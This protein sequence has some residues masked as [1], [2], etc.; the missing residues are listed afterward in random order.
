MAGAPTGPRAAGP[1]ARR[2]PGGLGPP[3][4]AVRAAGRG[5]APGAERHA[6]PLF[7]VLFALDDAGGVGRL[8][9]V[10]VERVPLR[11]VEA[12]FDLVLHLEEDGEEIRGACTFRA[13]SSTP[14]TA[15]R[16]GSTSGRCSRGWP[17]PPRPGGRR[18]PARRAR[19]GAAVLDGWGE[20]PAVPAGPLRPRAVRGAGRAHPG[21]GR[22]RPRR[23]AAHLRGAGP[24]RQ[25]PGAACCCAGRRP[26]GARGGLPG[27]L[28]RAGGG[29]AGRAQ[30]GRRLRAARP[31]ATPPSGWPSCSA[32]AARRGGA[33]AA[34][35]AHGAP[36]ARWTPVALDDVRAEIAAA[37]AG[38]LPRSAGDA[39]APGLRHLH[40]R[41]DRPAQGRGGAAPRPCAWPSR[42]RATPAS[43]AA[44]RVLQP[45]PAQPSTPRRWSCGA[46]CCRGGTAACCS[47][48]QPRRP[49]GLARAGASGTASPRSWLDLP[50]LFAWSADARAGL[51][52]GV[53]QSLCR[54]RGAA[55]RPRAPRAAAGPGAAARQRLRPDR[56]HRLRDL[57]PRCTRTRRASAVPI[58]RPVAGQ[59]ASTCSTGD[60][61]PVP[62]GVPGEL[63]VGGAGLA[64]GY[65][66]RP[67][68]TAERFVARPVR[69]RGRR[70]AVPHRRPG[71]LAAR[72]RRS[73]SSAGSTSR[74]RS[75]ASASS[76]ARSRRRCARTR[77]CARP[78]WSCARTRPAASGWSAYVVAARARTPR[79]RPSC[80]RSCAERLPEHM[81]PAGLRAR[82]TR[83]RSRPTARS[84]ARRCPRREPARHA[85]SYEP[86][87]HAGRRTALR[88]R[89]GPS[90]LGVDAGRACTTTS[91]TW[92]ATRCSPP[93]WSSRVRA[94]ARRRAAAARAVRGADRGRAW[95]SGWTR[96]CAA[97]GRRRRRA[98][99]AAATA[100]VAALL[101][102]GA[103][104]VP[105]PAR[106]G[107]RR[108][109]TCPRRCGCAAR[110]T[111]PRCERRLRRDRA[112]ARGAAHRLRGA[113]RRRAGAGRA[114]RAGPAC[115]SID[116]S[117][118]RARRGAEARGA[119]RRRGRE[120]AAAVRPGARAAAPRAAC[121]GWPRTS[122]L[123]LRHH[124]PHRRRR[125][126]A[127]R[128]GARAGGALRA[129]SRRGE[130]S[131]L[132]ELPVQYADFAVWQRELAA[133]A[134]VLE[135]A[136]RLLAGARWPARPALLELPAD[137]PRPAGAA[138]RGGA[139]ARVACRAEL[140]GALARAGPRARGRRSSWSLLAGLR[141]PAA[142]A[143]PAQDDVLVGSPD[144]RPQ[145]RRD[146]RG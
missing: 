59:H 31:G 29:A 43:T 97:R 57:P 4:P 129:P 90:V 9:G 110:S 23:R 3:G 7:Q 101:R 81:V 95:R 19:S 51:A 86:A 66:G 83:C 146:S 138:H 12:K 134:S 77:R 115:R 112:P 120:A 78:R 98:R 34:R 144:R 132:P 27:A 94:R 45:V 69:R 72:R 92:A 56:E 140:A 119:A 39:R 48:A 35:A 50:A 113:G 122:T 75:A 141:S 46:P 58:G 111:R 130:P 24:P 107:Q 105:R 85:P 49:A 123:L 87:A 68:L 16:L 126:V 18:R 65:L 88:R 64:R 55:A 76:W 52:R 61:A 60:L 62:V 118:L 44:R 40:L 139:R 131:P 8:G 32:E 2:R 74:S 106:A 6:R 1:G 36:G 41:L 102:P 14:A 63:Y 117:A 17:P 11:P 53:R 124:A 84:T 73:S 26:G 145:P 100:R 93:G 13:A 47:P 143:A 37:S 33:H 82:W 103:A 70:A 25:P 54:R 99:R 96:G 5:A 10:E 104:L 109:T 108:P 142:A 79:R 42:P 38:G 114:G 137:R 121:C 128:P 21:R 80:A 135:R 30:G 125:L 28:G 22:R 133:R 127:G 91:S 15:E 67:E 136:A 71:A 89:S 116:L 20:V